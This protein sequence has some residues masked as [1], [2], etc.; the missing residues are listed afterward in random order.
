MPEMPF[1]RAYIDN[2]LY[3]IVLFLQGSANLFAGLPDGAVSIE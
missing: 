3:H 1:G 2:R